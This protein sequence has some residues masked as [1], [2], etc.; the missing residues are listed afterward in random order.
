VD[1]RCDRRRL[2]V[3]T[4]LVTSVVLRMANLVKRVLKQTG[5][6]ILERVFGLIL[7][8]SAAARSSPLSA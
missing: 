7:D 8:G 3:L 2:R 5:I 6:A 4:F 1:R